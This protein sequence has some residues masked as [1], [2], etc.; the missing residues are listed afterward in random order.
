[1]AFTINF[2]TCQT[3]NCSEL[4]V[5]DTST[6]WVTD[7]AFADVTSATITVTG[8]SGTV[9]TF[10][11]T[12]TVTGAAS[13][14]DLVYE[15]EDL[16]ETTDGQYEIVYTIVGPAATYTIT[17]NYFFKCNIECCIWE[18]LAGIPA[19]Y[20]CDNCK[21]DYI[22]NALNAFAYLLALKS[23]IK[24]GNYLKAESTLD[25]LETMC[26]FENCDCS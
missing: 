5:T 18:L 17:I 10:D 21:D 15:L 23:H 24:K 2:E 11:V 8:P 22:R 20:N 6:G 9:D 16:S 14:D 25:T 3:S 4:T 7:L 12:A 13:Q 1:M 26:D 19:V